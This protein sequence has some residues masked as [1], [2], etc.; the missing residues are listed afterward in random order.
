MR[1]HELVKRP[2]LVEKIGEALEIGNTIENS[3]RLAGLSHQTYYNWMKDG[4]ASLAKR[5]KGEYLD[6]VDRKLIEF[7]E[8]VNQ[9]EAQ[10]I[11]TRIRLIHIAS[12]NQWQAAA[13]WLERRR[14]ND[15]ALKNRVELSGPEGGPVEVR[16]LDNAIE[17]ELARLA[18]QQEAGAAG[19]TEENLGSGDEAGSGGSEPA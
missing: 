13:W 3:M 8:R 9:A 6:E 14:P 16:Q 5:E 12:K 2:D 19:E 11:D 1:T 7:V 15:F 18:A 4:K 10:A 17:S